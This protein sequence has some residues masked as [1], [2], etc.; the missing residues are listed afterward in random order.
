[1]Q[2]K[3]SDDGFSVVAADQP[4]PKVGSGLNRS[5]SGVEVESVEGDVADF[6]PKSAN[7]DTVKAHVE[8][9]PTDAERVFD[10]EVNGK[11]RS[12]LTAWITDFVLARDAE[13]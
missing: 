4:D 12:G 9:N 10:L 1:M 13:D 11:N 7:I 3:Q 6:D 2:W 5:A 8:A